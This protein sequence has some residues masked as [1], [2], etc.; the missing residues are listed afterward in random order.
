L[1][2]SN[3]DTVYI[4]DYLPFQ[5]AD[6]KLWIEQAGSPN[7]INLKV[8]PNELIKRQRKKA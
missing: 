6:L 1:I 8:D 4:F 2:N 3:P 7:I 5:D